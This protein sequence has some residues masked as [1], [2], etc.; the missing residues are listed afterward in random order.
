MLGSVS[1]GADSDQRAAALRV[2]VIVVVV[3]TA[4]VLALALVRGGPAWFVKFGSQSANTAVGRAVLGDDV[5]VPFD[6]SQDGV[7]FWLLAREPMLG[8]ADRLQAD[9]DRPSY[10]AQRIAYPWLAAPGRLLGEGGLL[11]ALV[12]VNVLALGAGTWFTAR[13]A[14]HLGAPAHVGYVF[15]LNPA[16]IVALV[17]DLSEIVA[18]AALVAT[19]YSVRTQAWRAASV[20]G[21]VAVLAKEAAL[22]VVVAVALGARDAPRRRALLVVASVVPAAL[23]AVYVRARLGSEGFGSQEFTAVPFRGFADAWRLAWRPAA[24]WGDALVGLLA[25]AAAVATLAR[26]AQRRS[27]ELWAALPYAV[28]VPFLSF[29][30]VN[31]NINLVRA[32]GPVVLFL[33]VDVLVTRHHASAA[34]RVT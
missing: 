10:R 20:G 34:R 23:W 33:L 26:F 2:T 28:L 29:Q 12:V 13:L 7:Q 27:L 3:A 32:I 19:V 31:R 21:A 6:E 8:D 4:L 24:H 14:Q 9:L 18:L 16:V 30:V 5:V 17:L 15:A 25:L 11:W 22:A 1:G